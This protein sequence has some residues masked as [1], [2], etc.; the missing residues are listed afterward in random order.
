MPMTM[1]KGPKSLIGLH[2]PEQLSLFTLDGD[3]ESGKAHFT[4]ATTCDQIAS[5]VSGVYA[6]ASDQVSQFRTYIV[7]S[8]AYCPS[9]SGTSDYINGL[10][11]TMSFYPVATQETFIRSDW[12]A[13]SSD[14]SIVQADLNR[15]WHT[16]SVAQQT[17]DERY[18]KDQ[19]H[20]AGTK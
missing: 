2:E 15:V 9:A 16:L 14:W 10:A 4:S 7:G 1:N 8:C 12:S 13:L 19:R 20:P 6:L 3:E 5:A 17:C 11:S 18:Q